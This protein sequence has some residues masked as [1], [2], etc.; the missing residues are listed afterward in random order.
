MWVKLLAY[1]IEG[2]HLFTLWF[3]GKNGQP[4]KTS[5]NLNLTPVGQMHDIIDDEVPLIEYEED[6]YLVIEWH[7]FRVTHSKV[8]STTREQQEIVKLR[9]DFTEFKKAK[10]TIEVSTREEQLKHI[11]EFLPQDKN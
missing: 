6:I 10:L 9:R 8:L 7:K 4:I 3:Q 1:K 11:V 5:L 2:P